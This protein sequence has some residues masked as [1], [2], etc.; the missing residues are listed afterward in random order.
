M[1]ELSNYFITLKSGHGFG[2]VLAH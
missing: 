2:H 1:G